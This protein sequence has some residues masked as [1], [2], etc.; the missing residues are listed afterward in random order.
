[1]TEHAD[2]GVRY[3]PD[4]ECP[5]FS[6][7]LEEHLTGV[8]QG[9][10]PNRGRFCGHCY[11]PMS[12][13]TSRC[14]HCEQ[15]TDGDRPPV[16]QVPQRIIELLKAQRSTER[17]WVNGLAYIGVLIAVLGG[18]AVV[19]G[20]PVLRGNLIAATI[21]YALILLIGSRVGAGILGGY[22]GDRIGF[23]RARHTLRAQWALWL[24]QRETTSNGAEREGPGTSDTGAADAPPSG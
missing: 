21:V 7:R 9:A 14:P 22:Y 3:R 20:I 5:L 1:M 6:E 17:T 10:V 15:P 19:L 18:L 12:P 13:E 8:M 4:D 23:E 11:T 24:K 2:E 16:E